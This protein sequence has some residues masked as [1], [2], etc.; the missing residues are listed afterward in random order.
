LSTKL[1][2]V[3]KCIKAEVPTRM[4][5]VALGGF[6][7]HADERGTQEDLLKVVD[8]ILTSFLRDMSS[9]KYV[10]VLMYSEFG[11]LYSEF[12]R[13]VA[14]NASKGTDHGTA[15]P[16]FIA[17]VPVKGGFY[18]EEPSLTDHDDGDLKGSTEFRDIYH[19]MLAKTLATDP[20]PAVV[21]DAVTSASCSR[22]SSLAVG[23]PV[24]ACRNSRSLL[25]GVVTLAS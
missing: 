25:R 5:M 22:L 7:T 4:Y 18:G 19:E 24:V 6:D 15:G 2:V 23:L 12:G 21:R 16:V 8:E 14:A 9:D 17:G 1:N 3:S 20:Q 13:R 11:R 10:V